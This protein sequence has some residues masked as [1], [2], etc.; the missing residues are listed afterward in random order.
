M[1]FGVELGGPQRVKTSRFS[2]KLDRL[3]LLH[4]LSSYG[5]KYFACFA[6]LLVG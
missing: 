1:V 3:P 6:R 4:E 5:G 2:L